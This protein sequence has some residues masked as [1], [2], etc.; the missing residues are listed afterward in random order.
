MNHL[1]N[2]MKLAV[3]AFCNK[4]TEV[5]ETFEKQ[6]VNMNC[7]PEYNDAFFI[8]INSIKHL[9]LLLKKMFV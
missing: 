3:I 5:V 8:E 1:D 2:E 6:L 4:S 7:E 9:C